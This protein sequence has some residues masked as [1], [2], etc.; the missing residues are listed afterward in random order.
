[1]GQPQTTG[2]VDLTQGPNAHNHSHIQSR[3]LHGPCCVVRLFILSPLVFPD[4]VQLKIAQYVSVWVCV[5]FCFLFFS[6]WPTEFLFCLFCS[7]CFSKKPKGS[8]DIGSHA[9]GSRLCT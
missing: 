8:V 1:M 3:L 9:M 5:I 2:T 6:E 4:L 7:F